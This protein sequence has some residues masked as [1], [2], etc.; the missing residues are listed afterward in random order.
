LLKDQLVKSET[1]LQNEKIRV[2]KAEKERDMYF[3]KVSRLQ[4]EV[5]ERTIDAQKLANQNHE[6]KRILDSRE[7]E[8]TRLK[9]QLKQTSRIK[10][11]ILK[12]QKALD[13]VR[14]QTEMERD[15][16][17]VKSTYNRAPILSLSMTWM[18]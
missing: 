3:S 15:A 2:E 14:M 16:L 13:D 10:E 18:E 12:K 11:T 1:Q 6:H 17:R 7:D 4:Q 5:D 9:E 8:L